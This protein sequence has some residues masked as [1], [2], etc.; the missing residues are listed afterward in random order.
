M[1]AGVVPPALCSSFLLGLPGAKAQ[2]LRHSSCGTTD[3][4]GKRHRGPQFRSPLDAELADQN[5]YAD[6]SCRA[7][8][9]LHQAFVPFASRVGP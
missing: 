9:H 4:V 2:F 7:T 6:V 8:C 5:K 1:T 3:R